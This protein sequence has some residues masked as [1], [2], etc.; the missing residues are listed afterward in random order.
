MH[1]RSLA[2]R[3]PLVA[4]QAALGTKRGGRRLS[5]SQPFV[6]LSRLQE[7]RRRL[8]RHALPSRAFIEREKPRSGRVR[9][10]PLHEHL[11]KMRTL[12]CKGA[13]SSH[14]SGE[15]RT[16]F[17]K[18]FGCAMNV[19]DGE[20]C[21][22][23]LESARYK[24]VADLKEAD[25]I[26]VNTCAIRDAAEER[27]MQLLRQLR[28]GRKKGQQVA[29]LGCMA[30]RLKDKLLEEQ[31]VDVISGPDGYRDLPTL[32]S[33]SRGDHQA[34]NVQLSV[35]ET[36]A[37][38]RPVRKGDGVSAFISITRGCNNMCSYCIV[39]FTRG[40]ERSRDP[41]TIVREVEGLSSEGRIKEVVLLGQNVNS[42][43]FKTNGTGD[44]YEIADGFSDIYSLRRGSGVRFGELLE[45]VARVDPTIR[46]RFTSPHP[47][48]FT[49]D[50][51]EVIAKHKNI[52]K[53]LHLP[54]QSG[55]TR[56]LENMRRG[57][58]RE[59]YLSLVE[60]A[61]KMI[62][63]ELELSSDFI[64]GFCGETEADHHETLSLL[65]EVKF[66]QA[67]M[68]AYSDREQTHASR[69]L[70]D[71][72]PQEVKLRRLAEVVATFQEESKKKAKACIGKQVEVL[73]E[74]PSPRKPELMRGSSGGLRK[75]IVQKPGA[76][77]L[78]QGQYIQARVTDASMA[79][80][81][82]ERI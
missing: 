74:E 64:S 8:R 78:K 14:I 81:Y 70:V 65:R 13:E 55:S 6:P 15:G 1:G 37:D 21:A 73:I 79:T 4:L 42:Y 9:V 43:F 38:I 68:F 82:V 77:A 26:L 49:D 33:L 2:L 3:R 66:D 11:E 48:D 35:D 52:C 75:C 36:Y 20:V 58:S 57:Y 17:V 46:V 51:L 54:A 80:L 67:F 22:S 29:V 61:R 50:V 44:D 32:L 18:S 12:G 31:L 69:K 59:S 10:E 45:R 56:I 39:P 5:A 19:S 72:V 24:P 30:E 28:A 60:R 7:L 25:V 47:K 23:V 53:G 71:D 40:R 76:D 16:Y 41:D 34:M 27:A 63:P 62:G